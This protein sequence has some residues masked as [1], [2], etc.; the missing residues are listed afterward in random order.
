MRLAKKSIRIK[1]YL[2]K[3]RMNKKYKSIVIISLIFILALFLR[4]YKLAEYPPGFFLDEAS[5]GVNA[6]SL[7]NYGTDEWGNKWP[8]YFES[9]GEYKNPVYIYLTMFSTAFLGL[10]EIAIRL[11]NAILSSLTI[12]AFY[13][14]LKIIFKK[15]WPA[16]LGAFL[17]ALSPWHIHFSRPG[18]DGS[19]YFLLF[20]ILAICF[21]FWGVENQKSKYFYISVLFFIISY[22]SYTVMR[23]YVP[24]FFV[25]LI[26]T[27][28][29]FFIKR[30]KEL[31]VGVSLFIIGLLPYIVF[32]SSH[33]LMNR[34]Y[35]VSILS[36]STL[37]WDFIK[38][39]FSY[40]NLNFLFGQ[41][42][43]NERHGVIGVGVMY[44]FMLPFLLLGFYS[45]LKSVSKKW[46]KIDK[47]DL[48]LLAWL[49]VFPLA[50]SLTNDA[51]PHAIR[52][53]IGLP[54]LLII[55][56]KGFIYFVAIKSSKKIY[57]LVLRL[58]L[59]CVIILGIFESSNYLYQYFVVYPRY[60]A[61]S[62]WQYGNK[63]VYDFIQKNHNSYQ[64]ISF[65]F[66][67]GLNNPVFAKFYLFDKLAIQNK[68]NYNV[69]LRNEI[70]T[71]DILYILTLDDIKYLEKNK[72]DFKILN[73]IKESR[74]LTVFYLTE[75]N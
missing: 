1:L 12:L 74:G 22:Y 62:S 56:V 23:L 69:V 51:V 2:N 52:S 25:F 15:E 11:P 75:I 68:I 29:Q 13:W 50:G 45:L 42:D 39:Y 67:I 38:N 59:I 20:F 7:V 17:L 3:P 48:F 63:L 55:I 27:T 54:I 4:V 40:F 43:P 28:Y 58:S 57:N 6:Y 41:G 24:M 26:F 21:W 70:N 53:L 34:F 8:V 35:E 72:L 31:L 10:N 16:Y 19:A 64:Q 65:S 36:S 14:L 61:V 5:V 44:W 32:N 37:V 49:F 71:K 9:F 66:F 73:K 60:A 18:M 46:T 47:I 30:K 33:D